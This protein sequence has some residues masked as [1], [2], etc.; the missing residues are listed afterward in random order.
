M[1]VVKDAKEAQVLRSAMRAYLDGVLVEEH[2][3]GIDVA[4]GYI[5]GVGHDSGLL[6][7]V[8]VLLEASADRPFNIFDYR[9][10][11]L[12]R[13]RCSTAARPASRATS[14]PACA[15]SRP[16]SSR[17]PTGTWAGST[18]G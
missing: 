12:D 4:M 14:P 6:M 8:E 16:R 7:P 5:D 2:I 18:S 13:P 9:L 11:N 10:K 3:E 15:R 1:S 17:S